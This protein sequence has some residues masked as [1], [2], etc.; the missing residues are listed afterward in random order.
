M[1]SD[2]Q[3]IAI[4]ADNDT[5]YGAG[6]DMNGYSGVGFFAIALKGEVQTY[7][8]KVQQDTDPAFGT[9]AD[10]AGTNVAFATAADAD[11][12]AFV[13]IKNPRERYVRPALVVPNVT[14]PNAVAIIAI[15]Y[16][17]GILPE[18][19]ADGELHVYPAEG[20]A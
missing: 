13:E 6:V 18:T 14:T 17:K 9:A 12:F 8:L 20:T 15:R 11:G 3:F 2:P 1:Q 16:G 19:N 5:Y 4:D 7:G 10:L